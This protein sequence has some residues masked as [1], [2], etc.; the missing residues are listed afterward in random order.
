[1]PRT[2]SPARRPAATSGKR[3]RLPGRPRSQS[4]AGRASAL[5]W[6]TAGYCGGAPPDGRG[7]PRRHRRFAGRRLPV[8]V[9]DGFCR[10]RLLQDLGDLSGVSGRRV[11]GFRA[12]C[13]S[14]AASPPA[15]WRSGADHGRHVRSRPLAGGSAPRGDPTAGAL[16][17]RRL[18][19]VADRPGQPRADPRRAGRPVTVIGTAR[20]PARCSD[21]S[22]SCWPGRHDGSGWAGSRS[23]HGYGRARLGLESCLLAMSVARRRR[24]G[25]SAR[26]SGDQAV[27]VAVRRRRGRRCRGERALPARRPG[28]S[29]ERG[30]PDRRALSGRAR[31]CWRSP[32]TRSGCDRSRS[33][34]WPRRRGARADGVVILGS[35]P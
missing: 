5:V 29:A 4:R 18:C 35:S 7:R 17:R 13:C 30:R 25:H 21:S 11:A 26:T 19:V 23:W 24:S 27:M 10:A 14:I 12:S 28:G 15:R 33:P 31:C 34:G 1:M 8:L 3:N 9:L 22:P 32:S 6:G 2:A 16:A 20:W